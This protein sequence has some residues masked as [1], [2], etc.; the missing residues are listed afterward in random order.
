[1]SYYLQQFNVNKN[2]NP[3][4]LTKSYREVLEKEIN[5]EYDGKFTLNG[6]IKPGSIKILDIN[7]GKIQGSS[8]HSYPTF[9]INFTA[10]CLVFKAGDIVTCRIDEKIMNCMIA[11]NYIIKTIYIAKYI[12]DK[13]NNEFPE[14]II[15]YSNISIGDIVDMVVIESGLHK[16]SL[17]VSGY[18]MRKNNIRSSLVMGHIPLKFNYYYKPKNTSSLL[19]MINDDM[20]D[21]DTNIT[22]AENKIDN[23]TNVWNK[24]IKN[25]LGDDFYIITKNS[26]IKNT[27]IS[28]AYFKL[29]EVLTQFP[30]ANY[31]NSIYI[32]CL[33][34]AP[35][36]FCKAIYDYR[37]VYTKKYDFKYNEDD[38]IITSIKESEKHP[39]F[40]DVLSKLNLNKISK[41]DYIYY[42]TSDS[43]DIIDGD[44]TNYD[45]IKDFIENSGDK[46]HIITADGGMD[47]ETD[48]ELHH[49]KLF[50]GEII[51][52]LSIQEKG[53]AFIFKI[54][55]IY[56]N[57]TLTIILLLL[58]YYEEVYIYK[59]YC[60]KDSNRERYIVCLRMIKV[61]SDD[62]INNLLN[63]IK[64]WTDDV[65]LE[66]NLSGVDIQSEIKLDT[67]KELIIDNS[68]ILT[69][70]MLITLNRLIDYG[71]EIQNAKEHSY[72]KFTEIKR[73]INLDSKVAENCEK[74]KPIVLVEEL[75]KASY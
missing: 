66:I 52:A 8:L 9:N 34:E 18:I 73:R 67:I 44:M 32:A 23:I 33:S 28:R 49:M 20:K 35:G 65:D 2:L 60:S 64:N 69:N 41:N 48:K 31:R 6:Y 43:S 22:D 46:K 54:Y 53:G 27:Y 57:F 30:I 29:M 37:K 72:E 7:R 36:G 59:P 15:N 26:D 4:Y 62:E 1:M 38:Y 55:S 39:G 74:L 51:T 16:N 13:K 12:Q 56:S 75:V 68:K 10:K 58:N 3:K 71:I 5:N 42:G 25:V 19:N 47:T 17:T 21:L 61:L 45:V 11:S 70:L 40:S 24:Y 14:S 50:M 63:I